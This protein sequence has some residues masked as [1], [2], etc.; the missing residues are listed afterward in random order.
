LNVCGNG[1][2]GVVAGG[3]FGV[4]EGFFRMPGQRM[5]IRLNGMLNGGGRRGAMLGNA[6]GVITMMFSFCEG[7]LDDLDVERH[8]QQL[9]LPRNDLTTPMLAAGLAGMAY[10]VPAARECL[11]PL[12][13]NEPWGLI[14]SLVACAY[15]FAVS[16][17]RNGLL[18]LLTTG[19]LSMGA[20]T[21]LTYVAP[22]VSEHMP[23]SR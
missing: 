19:V 11:F 16:S 4:V 20:I 21:G 9:G 7:G 6:A 10:R 22:L 1:D 23:F 13:C 14:L 17:G 18:M 12:V 3:A 15:D 2:P 8:L 5:K